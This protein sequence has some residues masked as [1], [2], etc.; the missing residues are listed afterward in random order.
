MDAIKILQ[1]ELPK[2]F[3]GLVL[4][5]PTALLSLL[6]KSV[7]GFL[8][9]TLPTL[10]SNR[11]LFLLLYL[12]AWLLSLLV[13]Y[14][15]I[16]RKELKSKPDFSQYTHDPNKACWIHKTT[17]QRICEACKADGK[18]TPLSKFS[19]GWKCPIH[20]AIVDYHPNNPESPIDNGELIP[21]IP[22]HP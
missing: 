10:I 21:T 20:D 17:N 13:A 11:T 16:L 5:P 2:K 18:L 12:L 4:L 19:S 6:L 7:Q 1:E 14:I 9:E 22:E 15:F 3:L 8:T